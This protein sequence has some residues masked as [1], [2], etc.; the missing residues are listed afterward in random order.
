MLKKTMTKYLSLF[1][2]LIL[3]GC[4]TTTVNGIA[5][6]LKKLENREIISQSDD[7]E[8]LMSMIG[9]AIR[10]RF[11]QVGFNYRMEE[12]QEYWSLYEDK[13]CIIVTGTA[14]R[15][16]TD[17]EFFTLLMLK[18]EVV[19]AGIGADEMGEYPKDIIPFSKQEKFSGIFQRSFVLLMIRV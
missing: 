5:L 8:V 3:F 16:K 12:N 17:Y 19:Y 18:E 1:V 10:K 15:T 13:D 7:K 9:P 2:L 6:D 14:G 4:Q 11:S